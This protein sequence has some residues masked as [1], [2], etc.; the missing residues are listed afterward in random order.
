[1]GKKRCVNDHVL[2]VGVKQGGVK[3][4]RIDLVYEEAPVNLCLD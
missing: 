1:M 2:N 3:E 4:R